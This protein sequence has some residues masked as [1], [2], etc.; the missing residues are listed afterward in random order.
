MK[1]DDRLEKAA[2]VDVRLFMV[3]LDNSR[4]DTNPTNRENRFY[5]TTSVAAG[6]QVS[7]VCSEGIFFGAGNKFGELNQGYPLVMNLTSGIEVKG[8]TTGRNHMAIWDFNGQVYTWGSPLHGKLGHPSSTGTFAPDD[9]ESYPRKVLSLGDRRIIMAALGDTFSMFLDTEGRVSVIGLMRPLKSAQESPAS[10]I[11]P[12]DL[13][14]YSKDQIDPNV[15]FVKIVA[16]EKH[17]LGVDLTG[18]VYAWGMNDDGQVG[19]SSEGLASP[20]QLM[21]LDKYSVVDV[22]CGRDFS[23]VI[24]ELG[25]VTEDQI[26]SDFKYDG[27]DNA[28]HKLAQIALS[29]KAAKVIYASKKSLAIN[30]KLPSSKEQL[31]SLV[32][33]FVDGQDTTG[34]AGLRADSRKVML[35]D[36]IERFMQDPMTSEQFGGDFAKLDRLSLSLGVNFEQIFYEKLMQDP[37]VRKEM[38]TISY[39]KGLIVNLDHLE[40]RR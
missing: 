5:H 2:P 9:I 25:T 18:K 33:A 23:L 24:I 6:D 12:Q 35:Q 30:K 15:R 3:N 4:L 13:K 11:V 16:G 36:L 37:T 19:T 21:E 31:S 22:A 39:S 20:N 38:T 32:E 10:L 29:K 27:I 26:Y 17:S 14:A 1:K 8:V 28:R 40:R 34:F 7:Y